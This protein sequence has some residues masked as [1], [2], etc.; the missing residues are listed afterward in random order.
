MD[1]KKKPKYTVYDCPYNEGCACP[2]M[3]CAVCGWNPEVHQ[4][5]MEELLKA[6]DSE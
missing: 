1:K 6:K 4:K 5:R 2:K 3:R